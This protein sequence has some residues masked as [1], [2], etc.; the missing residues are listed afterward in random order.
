MSLSACWF[1][2]P[3]ADLD[4]AVLFYEHVFGVTL[5]RRLVDGHPMAFFPD[6]GRTD[7]APGA[8]AA[9][10]SYVPART[11]VRLYLSCTDMDGV[12]TRAQAMGGSILYP[13]KALNETTW[14]AEFEDCEGNCIALLG[15]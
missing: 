10:D 4:R 5:S 3:V 13:R 11:G 14:V 1:E 9:G 7:G 15:S 6:D 12:L 8:L 2:I